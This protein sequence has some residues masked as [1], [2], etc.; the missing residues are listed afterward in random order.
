MPLNNLGRPHLTA[1]QKTNIDTALTS[2]ET[3][4]LAIVPNF[5]DEERTRYGSVDEKNKLLVNSVRDYS[6]AQPAL[7]SPDVDWVEYEAD[8]QDRSFCDTREKRLT[9]IVKLLTD[10]KIAHDYDNYKDALDDYDYCQYKARTK[11]PGFVEKAA[12][13][14]QF[15]PNTGGGTK[16]V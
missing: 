16:I 15:F 3:I 11:T 8:Y 2:V 14:K 7:A 1:A 13:L 4:L 12:D 10:F 6:Q 5:T 9:N